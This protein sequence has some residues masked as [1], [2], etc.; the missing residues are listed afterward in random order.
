MDDAVIGTGAF[1]AAGAVVLQGT[2]VEAGWLY[3]GV[4]A[5]PVRPVDEKLR[6]IIDRTAVNYPMYGR[7]FEDQN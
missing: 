2:K 4:P 1:I 3:A 6:E 7:W 5:K